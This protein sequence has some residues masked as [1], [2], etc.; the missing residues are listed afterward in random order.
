MTASK[1]L[2]NL[3]ERGGTHSQNSGAQT[4]L[5]SPETNVDAKTC[6]SDVRLK[7]AP[8]IVIAKKK[9]FTIVSN[10]VAELIN[11]YGYSQERATALVLR[12]V[13]WDDNPPADNEIF[14]VM[15]NRR[16]SRIDATIALT[17][18][19]AVHRVRTKCSHLSAAEA[20]E[21]LAATVNAKMVIKDSSKCLIRENFEKE[22]DPKL[23]A[24][25]N[26]SSNR[27]EGLD[28]VNMN[29]LTPSKLICL[30]ST[31]SV[32]DKIA[33]C[34]TRKRSTTGITK[35]SGDFASNN[36]V[37]KCSIGGK[38][39]GHIDKHI[40]KKSKI[41]DDTNSLGKESRSVLRSLPPVNGSMRCK[42]SVSQV[43]EEQTGPN[44]K[45]ARITASSCTSGTTDEKSV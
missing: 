42:R 32:Q 30:P 9:F 14:Q 5:H 16:L 44:M 26:S 7:N 22:F 21:E 29:H 37:R 36:G 24:F 3:D 43:L 38:N 18:A 27:N 2:R 31:K 25:P 4:S 39:D 8:D 33:V 17:V 10:G 19:R 15:K 23:I 28:S 13:R 12:Q 40:A 41:V 1:E 34:H 11:C 20:I 6:L 35:N 45:R